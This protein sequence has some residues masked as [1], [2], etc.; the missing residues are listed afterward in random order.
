MATCKFA[1][2]ISGIRGSLG[3]L[4]FSANATS[5]YV[6]SWSM[7]SNPRSEPQNLPRAL[8]ALL[9]SEWRALSSAQRAAWDTWAALPAQARTN[10][11]GQSYYP[12]GYNQFCLINTR[13]IPFGTSLRSTPPSS[14]VPSPPSLT[15]LNAYTGASNNS[16]ITF[17][18]SPFAALDAIVTAAIHTGDGLLSHSY[19]QLI[20]TRDDTNPTSPWDIQSALEDLFGQ[21]SVGQKL[22]VAVAVQTPDGQRSTFTQLSDSVTVS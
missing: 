4:T 5:S 18:G 22:Y 17:S 3:G 12:S 6:K 7:P 21:L 11:L 16:E 1:A 13:I 14:A 2:I 15:A 9:P 8:T 19:R 20:L 10:S